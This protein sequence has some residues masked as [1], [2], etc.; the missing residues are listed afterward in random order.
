MEYKEEPRPDAEDENGLYTVDVAQ[1]AVQVYLGISPIV[2]VQPGSE[3]M[4]VN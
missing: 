4:A 3:D 1:T 2:G